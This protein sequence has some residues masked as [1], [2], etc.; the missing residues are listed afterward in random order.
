MLMVSHDIEE[1][2]Y[3]GDVVFFM[4]TRPGRILQTIRPGFARSSTDRDAILDVAEYRTLE[5]D[6]RQLM[7]SQSL[8]SAH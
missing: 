2:L 4:G 3:L 8:E 1:A 6:I 5:R 7:R